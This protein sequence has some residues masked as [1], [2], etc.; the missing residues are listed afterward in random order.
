MAKFA[1]EI[2][3]GVIQVVR[4]DSTAMTSYGIYDTSTVEKDASVVVTVE[5]SVTGS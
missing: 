3:Q 1:L 4:P 5:F 2:R